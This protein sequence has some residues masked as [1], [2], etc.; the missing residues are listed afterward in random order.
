MGKR[1]NEQMR[2]SE[3]SELGEVICLVKGGGNEAKWK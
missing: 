1:V 2:K 3:K